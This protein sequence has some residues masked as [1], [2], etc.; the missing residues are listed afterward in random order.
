[1]GNKSNHSKKSKAKFPTNCS[2]D[3]YSYQIY[4]NKEIKDDF[5][6]ID[7]KNSKKKKDKKDLIN[8]LENDS[9]HKENKTNINN[10]NNNNKIEE[11][12]KTDFELYFKKD[13]QTGEDILDE[14]G[15]IKIGDVLNIDIYSHMFFPYFFYKCEAKNIEKITK[16]EYQKG[17]N[18]F[19]VQSIKQLTT[20]NLNS[21]KININDSKFNDYYNYLYNLNAIKKIIPF[22]VVELY[23]KNF[24]SEYKYVNEFIDFLKTEKKECG[25]NKD[26]WVTFVEL[27]KT[28]KFDFPKSYSLEDS[29]PNLFDEFYYYYCKKHGIEVKKNYDEEEDDGY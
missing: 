22:E 28:V 4:K 14:D 11:K 20:K 10:Y 16:S 7:Y 21:W 29:W 15:L 9:N 6:V 23:Y 25:L 12:P 1:M 18:F 8:P 19:H 5:V 13:P 24:F 27:L 2:D 17:L 26:Q 3:K